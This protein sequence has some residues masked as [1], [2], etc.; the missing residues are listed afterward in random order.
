MAQLARFV[1]VESLGVILSPGIGLLSPSCQE[2]WVGNTFTSRIH[3]FMFCF[4]SYRREGGAGGD[5][6]LCL[7]FFNCLQHKIILMPQWNIL[8]WH[9]LNLF[10]ARQQT[11]NLSTQSITD[12]FSF[13]DLFWITQYLLGKCSIFQILSTPILLIS[14]QTCI[15][16][17]LVV[18]VD[19]SSNR[20]AVLVCSQGWHL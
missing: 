4:Q 6:I 5:L 1:C 9:T 11:L 10:M 17:F 12:A 2:K 7:Y 16:L 19:L 18:G 3:V 20:V 8:G 13:N 15:V 14:S